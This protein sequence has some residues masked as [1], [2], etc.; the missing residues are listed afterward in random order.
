MVQNRNYYHTCPACRINIFNAD[1]RIFLY[2]QA[3]NKTDEFFFF[4]SFFPFL[5]SMSHVSPATYVSKQA[6]YEEFAYIVLFIYSLFSKQ[7]NCA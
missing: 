7:V 2:N 6:I 3:G 5:D 1:F 4:L